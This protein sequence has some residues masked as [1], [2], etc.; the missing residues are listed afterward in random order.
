MFVAGHESSECVHL[1]IYISPS[2]S[3][4][5]AAHL[6]MVYVA[7]LSLLAEL[8]HLYWSHFESWTE[9]LDEVVGGGLESGRAGEASSKRDR[10]GDD[11]VKGRDGA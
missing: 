11:S 6:A 8:G 2:W 1:S 10:G 7:L 4:G 5:A 3:L 9:L